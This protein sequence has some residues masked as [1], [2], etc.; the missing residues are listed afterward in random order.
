M[1][2]DFNSFVNET[3]GVPDDIKEI[4]DIVKLKITKIVRFDNEININIQGF[5][6][7]FKIYLNYTKT[8]IKYSG[9]INI[10]EL[11]NNLSKGKYS[12]DIN[13][14]IDEYSSKYVNFNK[15]YSIIQHE[16]THFYEILSFKGDFKKSSFNKVS[17]FNKL[18][19]NDLL[20]M[21]YFTNCLYY[22]LEHELNARVSML[23]KYL[24]DLNIRDYNLLYKEMIKNSVYSIYEY[25][26]NFNSKKFMN[27]FE[28]KNILLDYTNFINSEFGY[29]EIKIYELEKYYKK[30]EIF[31]KK[32]MINH[33]EKLKR[34]VYDVSVYKPQMEYWCYN[35]LSMYDE[36]MLYYNENKINYRI[37]V[38]RLMEKLE[39]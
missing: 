27:S 3:R 19:N 38:N 36:M 22:T 24:L 29:K 10:F 25:V 17:A 7:N 6:F 39:L 4:M 5:D 28:D 23:Y 37:V 34:V 15:L 35:D 16:L 12:V 1:V 9:N 31:L 30:W 32:N 33:L 8:A 14:N 21:E 18:K 20:K 13:I 11:I 26:S 2:E